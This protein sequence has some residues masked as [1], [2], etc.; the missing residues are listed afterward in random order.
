MPQPA[1]IVS[2]QLKAWHANRRLRVLCMGRFLINPV[3]TVDHGILTRSEL[4]WGAAW[5]P[6]FV[7]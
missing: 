1:T 2:E 6:K 5:H 7:H 3:P 4:T